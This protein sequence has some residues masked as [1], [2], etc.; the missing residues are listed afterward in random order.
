LG[1]AAALLQL[2]LR[3]RQEHVRTRAAGATWPSYSR[4]EAAAAA[5]LRAPRRKGIWQRWW[6]SAAAAAVLAASCSLRSLPL[7]HAS[8]LAAAMLSAAAACG[9]L[10]FRRRGV[11]SPPLRET[12]QLAA[13]SLTPAGAWP[14]QADGAGPH[15]KL[16]RQGA[17]T[18]VVASVRVCTQPDVLWHIVRCCLNGQSAGVLRDVQRAIVLERPAADVCVLY[19]EV[20]WRFGPLLHGTNHLTTRVQTVSNKS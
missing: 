5:V 14:T 8:W 1:A 12:H 19:Q 3:R 20:K 6:G 2:C 7:R 9:A 11:P 18:R 10:L 15:I 16:T 13:A 17:R 4:A